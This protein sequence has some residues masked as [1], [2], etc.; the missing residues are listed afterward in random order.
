MADQ[1]RLAGRIARLFKIEPVAIA[2]GQHTGA[3]GLDRWKQTDPGLLFRAEIHRTLLYNLELRKGGPAGAGPAVSTAPRSAGPVTLLTQFPRC[4][5]RCG[6][7]RTVTWGPVDTVWCVKKGFGVQFQFPLGMVAT[8]VLTV[9]STGGCVT[10]LT[11]PPG[12]KTAEAPPETADQT[13]LRTVSAQPGF[14]WVK[15]Q[16]TRRPRPTLFIVQIWP[17]RPPRS[18][19]PRLRK[20]PFCSPMRPATLMRPM[21]SPNKQTP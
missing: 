12:F 17:N 2:H 16:Q 7:W 14:F 5:Q 3:K 21:N 11:P 9:L 8:L 20:S 4:C 6:Q 18:T 10:V 13:A 1:Y 15:T 19:R